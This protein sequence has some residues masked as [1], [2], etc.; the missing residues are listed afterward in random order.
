MQSFRKSKFL[1]LFCISHFI[2]KV[3][4]NLMWNPQTQNTYFCDKQLVNPLNKSKARNMHEKQQT[5]TN[6]FKQQNVNSTNN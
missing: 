6:H 4:Y 2:M 1:F 5:I 3:F